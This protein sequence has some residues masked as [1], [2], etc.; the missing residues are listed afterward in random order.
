MK[1]YRVVIT[2]RAQEQLDGYIGYVAETLKNKQAARAIRDDARETKNDLK[3]VAG[4]LSDMEELPGYKKIRFNKHRYVMIYRI[5]GDTVYADYVF[6]ELQ[7]YLNK[8]R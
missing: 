2:N 4:S 5:E 6:H 1:K 8:I 3:K 7:D